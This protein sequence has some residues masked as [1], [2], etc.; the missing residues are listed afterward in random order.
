MFS[1]RFS[2]LIQRLSLDL[3]LIDFCSKVNSIILNLT[4]ICVCVYVIM[5]CVLAHGH[6]PAPLTLSLVADRPCY[7][8]K[9]CIVLQPV[10]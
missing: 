4:M 3:A 9:P 2:E 10:I 1:A 6:G 7:Q 5:T 8:C